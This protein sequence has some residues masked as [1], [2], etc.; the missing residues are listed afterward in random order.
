[1]GDQ[2]RILSTACSRALLS[3]T[4]THTSKSLE[5]RGTVC[6][7]GYWGG[8]CLIHISLLFFF[9]KMLYFLFWF[10]EEQGEAVSP[11]IYTRSRRISSAPFLS[12]RVEFNA[13]LDLYSLLKSLN[14]RHSR[15][16]LGNINITQDIPNGAMIT[17]CSLSVYVYIF[18]WLFCSSTLAVRE[19][20]DSTL[21]TW[22]QGRE[23]FSLRLLCITLCHRSSLSH[24]LSPLFHLSAC[25]ASLLGKSSPVL[26]WSCRAQSQI[27]LLLESTTRVLKDCLLWGGTNEFMQTLTE[28]HSHFSVDEAQRGLRGPST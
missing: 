27:E 10:R 18:W 12:G 16:W 25:K 20:I 6:C 24:F 11:D 3:L 17:L 26:W 22:S 2:H 1:M 15:K 13:H 23:T 7:T 9:W 8:C 19:N 14:R 5:K 4:V 21:R 28:I